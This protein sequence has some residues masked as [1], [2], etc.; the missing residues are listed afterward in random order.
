MK[1][2]LSIKADGSFNVSVDKQLSQSVRKAHTWYTSKHISL[3]SLLILA[4]IDILGFM[5]I[6]NETIKESTLNRLVIISAFS[7]AFEV[8]PMYIGYALS[9]KSYKLGKPIHNWVLGFSISACI[10]G[11]I[12]NTIFRILTMEG[13]YRNNITDGLYEFALPITIVM[14]ILP[15]ITSLVNLVISCLSFDPL[16]FDIARFSKKLNVLKIRKRQLEAFVE[17]ISGDDKLEEILIND[18]CQYYKNTE[19]EILAM[20]TR[21]YT[22]VSTQ[23][24]LLP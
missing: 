21:L 7:V 18:E 2:L 20:R 1:R 9:L 12:G 19:T 17:E 14:C 22:Y 16:L 3:P 8:A 15:V 5:Q 24:S 23:C 13:A 10:L 4:L 6:A 11:V